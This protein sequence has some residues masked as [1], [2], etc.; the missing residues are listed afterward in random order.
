MGAL[1]TIPVTLATHHL[2]QMLQSIVQSMGFGL[3]HLTSVSHWTVEI[4]LTFFTQRRYSM[5]QDS[6]QLSF[7]AVHSFMITR[8]EC[9]WECAK[10]KGN[11]H[12][13]N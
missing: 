8:V 2:Y 3:K 5:T 12:M 7:T 11:G 13:M 1:Q 4:H 9:Q 10:P 6:A